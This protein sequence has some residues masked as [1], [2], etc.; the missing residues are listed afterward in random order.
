MK[1][2]VLI[3]KK[4]NL[5]YLGLILIFVI[6]LFFF[7]KVNK[8]YN[9]EPTFLEKS[10]EKKYQLDLTGDGINDD[11][12]I[13]NTNEVYSLNVNTN[14]E[15]LI[16]NTNKNCSSYGNYL[17]HW[18]IRINFQDITRNNIPE[19]ILQ[20]QLDGSANTNIIIYDP[21]TSSFVNIFY[22]KNNI[23]G[24]L[25]TSNNKTPKLISS[26]LSQNEMIISS[27]IF[28]K[29][30][31]Q[32][33]TYDQK[34]DEN[35]FCKNLII[36]LTYFLTSKNQDSLDSL[37]KNYTIENLD[38]K[39]MNILNCLKESETPLTFQ[40]AYFIDIKSDQNGYPTEIEWYLSFS[41]KDVSNNDAIINYTYKVIATGNDNTSFKLSSISL[42][43]DAE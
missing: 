33:F 32:E 29:D 34:G 16:I 24:L 6:L 35:F 40:D 8:N 42:L 5:Y 22:R 9:M 18:P 38:S 25:D 10:C 15:S 12:Y 4:E 2:H 23:L 21:L 41:G 28:L 36:K 27:Y 39:S 11:L 43:N 30:K 20:S 26:M 19:I 3:K 13:L 17:K 31:F 7:I 37:L 1:F 14:S